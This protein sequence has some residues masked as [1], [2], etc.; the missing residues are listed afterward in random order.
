M[1]MDWRISRVHGVTWL[2]GR[3]T[4]QPLRWRLLG[5]SAQMAYPG[6]LVHDRLPQRERFLVA[7]EKPLK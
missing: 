2:R 1:H 5:F 6:T 7:D 4:L 3:R